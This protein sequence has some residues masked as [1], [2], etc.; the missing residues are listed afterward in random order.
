MH[1]FIVT[2]IYHTCQLQVKKSRK[3]LVPRYVASYLKYF[4]KFPNFVED[5]AE[6]PQLFE[7]KKE[8]K[9]IGK[10]NKSDINGELIQENNLQKKLSL[11]IVYFWQDYRAHVFTVLAYVT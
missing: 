9:N 4:L 2:F 8:K 11:E 5:F 6:F 1:K 10:A 7:R 3:E